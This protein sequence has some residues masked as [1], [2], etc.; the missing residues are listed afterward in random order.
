MYASCVGAYK[1]DCVKPLP[2]P[3]DGASGASQAV[4][5]TLIT[6]FLLQGALV[7]LVNLA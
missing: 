6:L 4:M 1:D 5:T 7:E 2:P 3:T